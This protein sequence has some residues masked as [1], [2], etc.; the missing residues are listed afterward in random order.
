MKFRTTVTARSRAVGQRN[1]KSSRCDHR[2]GFA[3]VCL[4]VLAVV[5]L[6]PLVASAASPGEKARGAKAK[7]LTTAKVIALIKQHAGTGPQGVSG[8]AG[9]PG[10]AGASGSPDTGAQILA[11][12]APVDGAGSGLD[13]DLLDG[14]SATSYLLNGDS[15][16]G[17]LTGTY[18]S[19]TIATAFRLPTG[20]SSTEVPKLTFPGT[21]SCAADENS[22]GDITA[23]TTSG[24]LTG[25]GTSGSVGVG[26]DATQI[27]G[28]VS[29]SCPASQAIRVVAQDGTVTCEGVGGGGS[30]SGPA[31]GD[32]AGNYPDPTIANGAVTDAKVA[33][34]NTDGLPG[35]P[36]LRTLGTGAQQAAAGN[37]ARL[38]DSR[39]PSGSAGGDLTGS[40]PNPTIALG[41]VTD[42]KVAA[43]NVEG[44]AGTPSLRTLGTGTQQAA[45]GDDPR[46]SNSRTPTG[47][48]GGDL[49]NS[50]YPNPEL[51]FG[52]VTDVEVAFANK[53]G[54]AAVPSMRTLGTG[55]QQAAAG[56]DARLS[57]S[58]APSGTAG[59]ALTGTYPNP[60]LDVSGGT[61]DSTTCTNG[62]AVK[63]LS[64]AAALTCAPGVFSSG[65]N[66]AAGPNMFPSLSVGA[67]NTAL[68]SSALS[69]NSSGSNNSAV[70]STAL[71]SNTNGAHNSAVGKEALRSNTSGGENSAVGSL[72]LFLNTTGSENAAIGVS[73][74]QSN[75]TANGNSA[76]GHSALKSNTTGVA[77][78]AVG[79][80]ALD[81]NTTASNNSALGKDALGANT[82]GHSNSAV[83]FGAL[84]S[85]T[86]AFG[87][88]ALGR[89]ALSSSTIGQGNSAVGDAALEDNTTAHFNSAVGQDTLSQNTTGASN[90]AFGRAALGANTTGSNNVGIGQLGGSALTTG[91]DN[92]AIANNGVAAESATTRIGSAQTRAFIAG[93][94]GATTGV[95]DAIPVMVD[96]AGQLGTISSSRTVKK[97]IQPLRSLDALMQLNPVSFRYRE[98]P[99]EL[100]YGL[101]A[102][103]VAEVLPTLAVY[104][105]E[106][107]PETVQYQEL[108]TLLLAQNQQQQQQLK[109]QQRQIDRQQAQIDLL[110]RE[111]GGP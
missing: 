25:G 65:G 46:L 11:K 4:S 62:E 30:P 61:F 54:L 107:I 43:A 10:A 89:G 83:G 70:G 84:A 106:G 104:D 77:N 24:G 57:D 22:G 32:L 111:L 52:V 2:L 20:C 13:A 85:N 41:V 100:H 27:Q 7:G 28:R 76:V 31:G 18:P 74:L 67:N 73:A 91:S 72:A 103:Q 5:A 79:A 21:W 56:N 29:G 40:Y 108:P 59:G 60:D 68:G 36:S 33:A 88:S 19:P 81:V 90:S 95:A 47:P 23:V 45:A 3:A 49:L 99:P 69:A 42:S 44:T 98:G 80:G 1:S 82:T 102:E 110:M 58:R 50:S 38:S 37:D 92:I 64:T 26:V 75:T 66:V 12:L 71:L 63:A 34:A 101:V 53:D 17:D 96:S 109:Q 15:A 93:V 14:L 16:G 105:S 48:A 97:D 39:T 8:A 51:N 78:A 55:A 87:N 86:T 35:V 9:A 94:R 6:V